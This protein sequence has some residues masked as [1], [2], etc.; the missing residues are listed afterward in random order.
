MNGTPPMIDDSL[1]RDPAIRQT[2]LPGGGKVS[3]IELHPWN[4][5]GYET[6]FVPRFGDLEYVRRHNRGRAGL[7]LALVYHEDLVRTLSANPE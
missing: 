5:H 4:Q 1:L 2:V 3:T 7:T 6:A